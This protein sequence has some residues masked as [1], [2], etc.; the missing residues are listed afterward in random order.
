M[1]TL[2]NTIR[3]SNNGSALVT[4]M[5]VI[6]LIA[7]VG[8]GMVTLGRQQIYSARRMRDYAKA[9]I[10]AESGANAAY[11]L[12][13][14]NFAARTNP[15]NFPLT[16][17]GDGTYDATVVSVSSNLASITSTGV[18]G[19][20]RAVVRVDIKNYPLATS[21]GAPIQGQSPYGFAVLSGGYLG[22]SGGSDLQMSNG[23]MHG[24]GYYAANGNNSIFGNIESCT[25]IG[26]VGGAQI[27]GTGRAP[28]ISGG[29]VG[30]PVVGPVPLVSIPDIDLAPYYAAAQAQGQVFNTATKYLSGNVSPPGGIMW[31][32]GNISMAEGNYTGCFIATGSIELQ[33]ASANSSI[34]NTKVNKY[35]VLV[36]RDGNILVKQAK[37]WTFNGLVYV[38]TG[39]FDK[40]GN[41]DVV[42]TGAIIAAGNVTKNGGW[43]AMLYSDPTPIPPGGNNMTI[44]DKVVITAWQD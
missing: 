20:A 38:K 32:N 19:L 28:S 10:I 9:Q 11:S 5:G 30:T 13:K 31:V 40:Q 24:N 21:N 29:T 3:G 22:W 39:S 1:K 36:S 18:C 17:F 27:T 25:S 12:L 16:S 2:L 34:N 15:D 23:W 35:P 41:G 6:L 42:G 14:T 43:T 4:V 33:T 37:M 8:A 7:V 26:M 44:A